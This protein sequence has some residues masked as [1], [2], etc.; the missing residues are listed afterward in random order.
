MPLSDF[1]LLNTPPPKKNPFTQWNVPQGHQIMGYFHSIF[2]WMFSH[3]ATA[4][5][6]VFM[7]ERSTNWCFAQY[8][9]YTLFSGHCYFLTFRLCCF[10]IFQGKYYESSLKLKM[11][12][13]SNYTLEVPVHNGHLWLFLQGHLPDSPK[14]GRIKIPQ[15]TLCLP[16]S[17]PQILLGQ[18]RRAYYQE[19]L[20]TTTN[21]ECIMGIRK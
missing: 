10:G 9:C 13:S 5:Y 7:S 17:P 12:Q 16:P 21:P 20:K 15:N 11:F 1:P 4:I 14:G 19:K 3:S 2:F 8:T 6:N 18:L